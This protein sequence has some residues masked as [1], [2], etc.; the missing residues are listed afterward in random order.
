MTTNK[1]PAR[2]E[3]LLRDALLAIVVAAAV[4]TGVLQIVQRQNAQQEEM[5]AREFT[6]CTARWQRDFFTA[7]SARADAN[8]ATA[9]SIDGIVRA[10]GNDEGKA[11]RTAIERYLTVRDQQIRERRQN[12]LP[13]LPTEVCGRE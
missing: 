3:T 2:R 10:V 9:G 13:P 6:A 12:P 1:N 11:L 4:L 8:A 5:R 7:Y